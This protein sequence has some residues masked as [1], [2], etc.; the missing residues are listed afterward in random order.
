MKLDLEG[1]TVVVTGAGRGI[2]L[3]IAK[4]FIREGAQVVAGSHTATSELK[5]L[6]N[7][8][9]H[10]IVEVDLADPSGPERLIA[11]AKSVDVLV[12]NVGAAPP[13]SRA[14]S[15]SPT[16]CGSRR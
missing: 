12:N 3:A 11:A 13:A 5:E 10:D 2:G 16:T 14:S 9:T 15:P 1:Q 8:G 6:A 7:Q 4:A